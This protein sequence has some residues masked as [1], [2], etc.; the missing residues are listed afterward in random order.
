MNEEIPLEE[1]VYLDNVLSKITPD[2]SKT[3]VIKLLGYP[4]RD[5]ELKVNWEV[6][7][8]GNRN[9]I[10]M[11]FSSKT[12]KATR[13]DFDGGIGRFYYRKNLENDIM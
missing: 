9:R 11:F 6:I 12:G 7:I 10:G 4:S 1:K 5:N 13:I 2:S 8:N 3:D